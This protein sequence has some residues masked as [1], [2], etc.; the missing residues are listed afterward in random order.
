MRKHKIICDRCNKEVDLIE[1]PIT[2][3]NP[4]FDVPKGWLGNN[5]HI[6]AGK[7]KEL[8]DKCFEDYEKHQKNFS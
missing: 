7:F 1:V 8:C 2:N 3:S 5:N 4:R 6:R